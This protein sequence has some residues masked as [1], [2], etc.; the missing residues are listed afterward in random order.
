MTPGNLFGFVHPTLMVLVFLPALYAVWSGIQR[1]RCLHFRVKT[2][3]PWKR[4]VRLGTLA[5]V[6]WILGAPSGLVGAWAAFGM[7]FVCGS[8]AVVGCVASAMALYALGS[9]ML[10][11]RIK[12]HRRV[13]AAAHGINNC[14]LVLLAVR[15]F[16]D[17][18]ELVQLL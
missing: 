9:G 10:L 3:F 13:L 11:P 1:A 5:A 15:Q 4:H 6:L 14:L 12:K 7:T 2:Q 17:G 18:K 16:W 8:H